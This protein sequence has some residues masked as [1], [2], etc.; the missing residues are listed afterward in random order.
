MRSD[1]SRIVKINLSKSEFEYNYVI[2]SIFRIF[3]HL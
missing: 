1:M 2:K 3:A